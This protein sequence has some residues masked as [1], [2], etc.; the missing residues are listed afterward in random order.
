[1]PIFLLIR[2]GENDYMKKGRLAGRL[3]GVHLNKDGCTQV[4]ALAE[5]L[6]D[7]QIKAV[8]SSPL[9]RAMETANPIAE[10]LGLQVEVRPAL[11]EVDFGEWQGKSIRGLRRLKLWKTVQFTPSRARFPG[12]E[13]F[14]EAQY[15]ICKELDALAG[16]F[17]PKDRLVC[18][19]HGDVIKLAV[20]HFIGLPLDLFQRLHIAPA[21]ITTL[22]VGEGSSCLL[23]LNYEFSFTLPKI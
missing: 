9:D 21:S 7:A 3:A 11:S 12:G 22:S 1:M 13:S 5:R 20:A 18:V 2:H 10:I 23:N 17:E 15:R 6:R 14:A 4:R 19:S 8:F 16:E